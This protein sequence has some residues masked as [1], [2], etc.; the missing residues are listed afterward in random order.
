MS[1]MTL[2]LCAITRFNISNSPIKIVEFNTYTLLA[3]QIVFDMISITVDDT[4]EKD[5]LFMSTPS[6]V[7]RLDTCHSQELIKISTDHNSLSERW[8]QDRAIERLNCWWDPRD[9]FCWKSMSIQFWM[10][11]K[12]LKRPSYLVLVWS[13]SD[14]MSILAVPDQRASVRSRT[15]AH[16]LSVDSPG[17]GLQVSAY[18]VASTDGQLAF[19]F[20][21]LRYY[22]IAITMVC[23]FIPSYQHELKGR[24]CFYLIVGYYW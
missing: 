16:R 2:R 24:N 1:L 22:Y 5:L 12:E 17:V 15:R 14:W 3:T 19:L 4:H 11:G 20:P 9:T 10:M 18:R 21:W 7:K 23:S 8:N 13:L 6:F